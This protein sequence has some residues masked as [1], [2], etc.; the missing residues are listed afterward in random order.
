MSPVVPRM[1]VDLGDQFVIVST[2]M[3]EVARVVSKAA[4]S[5]CGVLIVGE[6]GTGKE[7]IARAV[8]RLSTRR[9][10]RFEPI[11]CAAIPSE[12]FESEVF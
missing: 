3:K 2:V 7:E 4:T 1:G 11:A 10:A 12:L 6:S 8:H 5:D 9:D